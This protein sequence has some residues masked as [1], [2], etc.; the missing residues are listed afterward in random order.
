LTLAEL[1]GRKSE[2]L[3]FSTLDSEGR[4]RTRITVTITQATMIGHR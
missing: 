4:K 2:L 3:L 1:D